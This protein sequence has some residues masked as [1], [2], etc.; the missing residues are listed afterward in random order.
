MSVTKESEPT[1]NSDDFDPICRLQAIRRA[2]AIS[3]QAS[4]MAA[5]FGEMSICSTLGPNLS[6][7]EFRIFVRIQKV[8]WDHLLASKAEIIQR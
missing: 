3:M 4:V 5:A 8:I 6:E 1:A 7:M 2:L